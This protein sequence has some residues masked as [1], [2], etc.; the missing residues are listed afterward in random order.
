MFC[1]KCGKE[2]TDDSQFCGH[3]GA[4]LSGAATG[5]GQVGKPPISSGPQVYAPPL[6][7]SGVSPNGSGQH[8]PAPNKSVLLWVLG[9]IALAAVIALVLVFVAFDGG[10]SDTSGPQQAVDRFWEALEKQDVDMLLSTMEPSYVSDLEEV[11]GDD[12]EPFFEDYFFIAFPDDL[13]VTIR[14]MET[15]IDG[16]EAVVTIVDGTMTYTDEYGDE[17]TEEA[18][19]SDMNAIPLVRVDGKWYLSRD[20]LDDL[21]LNPRSVEDLYEDEL[22]DTGGAADGE[23][24]NNE[25]E[26]L[27]EVEAAM[28]AYAEENSGEGLEFEIYDLFIE[29]NEAVGVAICTNQELEAPFIIMEKGSRGWYGVDFGTGWDP[30]VWYEAKLAEVEAAMIA[31]VEENASEGLE[32]EIYNLLIKGNEA[33]GVAVCTNQEV[34]APL[35]IMERGSRGWY[36]V[37]VGTGIDAP[38]WYTW[39]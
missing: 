9:G 5:T 22:D 25:E 20:A 6:P 7:P 17:V 31:Y 10:E 33:V 19:E 13:E 21:G 37:N 32:F 34:D 27:A 29:G 28:I 39:Y 16:D 14:K 35:V 1:D 26:E 15:E 23:D 18:S 4:A 3:C 12:L 11:L 30:P 8:P 24:Y 36:G 38:Y 2:I